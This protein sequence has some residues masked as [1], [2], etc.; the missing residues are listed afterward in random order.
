MANRRAALP[1]LICTLVLAFGAEVVRAQEPAQPRE[2]NWD[3]PWPQAPPGGGDL[4]SDLPA[5]NNPR[6][7]A[8]IGAAFGAVRSGDADSAVAA[9]A[10]P[11]LK[12]AYVHPLIPIVAIGGA[13]HRTAYESDRDEALEL[14][15]SHVYGL[16]VVGE[17]RYP[18]R[19]GL[20]PYLRAATGPSLSVLATDS[21]FESF[22]EDADPAVGWHFEL[23]AGFQIMH[24]RHFGISLGLCF[25]V[26]A[27]AHD[28]ELHPRDGAPISSYDI[29]QV[30]LTLGVHAGVVVPL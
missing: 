7:H 14:G 3:E 8:T 22:R 5:V 25:D 29:S 6:V 11:Q 9:N 17:L 30:L 26:D 16:S 12:L 23:S 21:G 20:M 13:L 2:P 15:D 19:S 18:T 10:A 4:V 27:V 1:L 24:A 28:V